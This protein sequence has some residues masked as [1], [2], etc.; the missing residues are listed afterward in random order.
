MRHP[1]AILQI[2]EEAA[3]GVVIFSWPGLILVPLFFSAWRFIDKR[4]RQHAVG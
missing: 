3:M 2:M 1:D 4:K